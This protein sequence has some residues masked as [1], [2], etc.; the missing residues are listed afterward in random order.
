L[1]TAVF[2]DGIEADFRAVIQRKLSELAH[3]LSITKMQFSLEPCDWVS[4]TKI[5]LT[6]V[7]MLFQAKLGSSELPKFV[8]V[9]RA[10]IGELNEDEQ[11]SKSIMLSF[12]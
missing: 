9:L 12:S 4:L 5:M 3:K 6:C 10:N 2:L 1:Y 8:Q 7:V 11:I